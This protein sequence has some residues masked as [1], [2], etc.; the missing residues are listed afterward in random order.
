MKK[1]TIIEGKIAAPCRP[2]LVMERIERTKH[3]QKLKKL[4]PWEPE[5]NGAFLTGLT[6]GYI[7]R[8]KYT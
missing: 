7:V 2:G 1:N 3:T 8:T 5:N 6:V 4:Q